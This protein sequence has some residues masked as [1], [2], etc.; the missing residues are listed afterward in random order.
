MDKNEI[1]ETIA[2]RVAFELKDG[3]VVNLGIG[4]PTMVPNY[5]SEGVRVLLQSE[6]GMIGM[7]PAPKEGEEDA[8]W[9][10]AGGGSISAIP[11]AATFDSATSFGIIRGG[12]VDVSVLGA[13]EVDENGDLANWIIPGKKAPGMGGAMDLLIGTRLVILAMEHTAKGCP[14]IL[15]KC[16][17]PL[18]AQGQVDLIIT[19]M[20][21]IE[22]RK[23]KG[24]YVTEI[25]PAFSKE[26]IIAATEAELHFVED[27]KPMRQ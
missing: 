12:H 26:D 7:G 20:C 22:V 6:N 5:L 24:L 19:E 23:G 15:K 14:K 27:L 18:T 4:L 8:N 10:N 13:L 9:V 2:K 17:L 16:H 3:D 25:N 21:V 1:R 11:G